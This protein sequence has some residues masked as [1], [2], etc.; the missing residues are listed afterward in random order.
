M[1]ALKLANAEYQGSSR[2]ATPV[3]MRSRSSCV[4]QRPGCWKSAGLLLWNFT[5]ARLVG[6]I[7]PLRPGMSLTK[8]LTT[9]AAATKR[10]AR[11]SWRKG[12][13]ESLEV[14][15]PVE[16]LPR[17]TVSPS[18]PYLHDRGWLAEVSED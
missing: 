1:S 14:R 13:K 15:S 16:M 9:V 18:H 17:C 8:A 11:Q 5:L 6:G 4:C 12:R 2:S 10:A 7:A 3:R